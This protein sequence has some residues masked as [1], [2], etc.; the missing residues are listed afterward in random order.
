[1]SVAANDEHA[2]VIGWSFSHGGPLAVRGCGDWGVIAATA[3][4]STSLGASGDDGSPHAA[5]RLGLAMKGAVVCMRRYV[6]TGPRTQ[7]PS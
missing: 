1:M 2:K 6:D 5:A 7:R 4:G 3:A